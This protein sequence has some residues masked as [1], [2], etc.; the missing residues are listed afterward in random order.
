MS[1]LKSVLFFYTDGNVLI[2]FQSLPVLQQMEPRLRVTR[3]PHREPDQRPRCLEHLTLRKGR[4]LWLDLLE[5]DGGQD[6][7]GR[8]QRGQ[9]R[10]RQGRQDAAIRL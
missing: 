5:R 2:R 6:H 10:V 8:R 1:N 7:R 3:D 9:Q 4:D